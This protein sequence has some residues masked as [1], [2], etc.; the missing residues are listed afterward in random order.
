MG[1]D[2]SYFIYKLNSLD[3]DSDCALTK[4]QFTQLL[5]DMKIHPDQ[6]FTEACY[7][8]LKGR[9]K[10]VTFQNIRTLY[11]STNST[12]KNKSTLLIL[13]R[14]V[15]ASQDGY[16]SLDEYLR[17]VKLVGISIDKSR[18][19]RTFK[20]RADQANNKISYS[21]VASTVFNLRVNSKEDP[22]KEK[23]EVKSPHSACCL[24]I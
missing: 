22:F 23:I 24:L 17:L 1:F 12:L 2:Y 8:S 18:W 3:D 16:L 9:N 11:E 15:A 13:F 7:T 21:D 19:E 14:G 20:E 10:L 5:R 4:T 6:D